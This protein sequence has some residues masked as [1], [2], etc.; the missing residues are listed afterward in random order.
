MSKDIHTA[1]GVKIKLGMRVFPELLADGDEQGGT[2]H[3]MNIDGDL[4]IL[5]HQDDLGPHY[6]E[7]VASNVYSSIKAVKAKDC[8]HQNTE[9]D[10]HGY[11]ICQDCGTSLARD[12]MPLKIP[13]YRKCSHCG[14]MSECYGICSN[15]NC[16]SRMKVKDTSPLDGEP[17]RIG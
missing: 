8:K 5:D 6:I 4:V 1:D 17:G 15:S 13:E 3:S 16:P 9:P 10:S 2:I 12:T 7:A 11:P 14:D